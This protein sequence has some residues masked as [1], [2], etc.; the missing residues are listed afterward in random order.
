MNRIRIVVLSF[1]M[2]GT[3]A[4]L[5]C[6]GGGGADGG[7]SGS[8]GDGGNG[9]N[10]TYDAGF[11]A[12]TTTPNSLGVTFSGETLSINGLPFSPVSQGDPYFVDGWSLSF[13]RY[14]FVVGNVRLNEDPLK[15]STWQDMGTQV[16]IKPGPFVMDGHKASGFVGKDGVEPASGIFLWTQ[17][18]DGTAFDTGKRYAFSYDIVQAAYPATNVNLD[19][20]GVAAYDKMVK[21]HWSKYVEGTATYVG[22]GT[23]NNPADPN[24]A[25][26]QT[27]FAAL[28]TTVHFSFGWDD[29]GSLLNCVNADLG[30]EDDLSNRGVQTNPSSMAIAQITM[31]SD[32]L[33]WDTLEVEGEP[34][35]FDPIAAWAPTDGVTVFDLNK[36]F[37][38]QKLATVFQDGTPI[39]D[40]GPY[41]PNPNPTNAG[42][43]FQTDMG[44]GF[45]VVMNPN[46]VST[47]NARDYRT[48]MMF[49]V[50]SQAHLNAQG[51]CYVVG[52]HPSDPYFAPVVGTEAE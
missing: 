9:L 39:P 46:G 16:A 49:S 26:A 5:G 17:K 14:L 38:Q 1:L 47:V 36:G 41:Q 18:D 25:H 19:S 48:F 32:H 10:T 31:H 52:Q 15:D 6:S 13:D 40:R 35:R 21:N 28:P 51:L 43:Q 33:F 34:L 2:I 42:P 44:N 27:N 23:Y 37:T 22:T 29:H 12:Q 8:T 50:Q 7:T 24:A 20:A 4:L 30:A 11:T 45:Q 3:G